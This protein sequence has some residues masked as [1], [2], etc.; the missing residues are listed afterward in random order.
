MQAPPSVEGQVRWL[1]D[2]AQI[3][4]LLVEYARLVDTKD[5]DTLTGYFVD[6][7]K[8]VLPFFT[9]SKEEIAPR[10]LEGLAPYVATHH[11]SANH[12]ITIDGDTASSRSYLQAVHVP[13]GDDLDRHGDVGGW[14]DCTYRR[15]PEGWRFVEVNLTFVWTRGAADLP[16]A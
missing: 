1:V 5:F 11:L 12:A 14:Y 7:G 10:S 9:L 15:T 4:D 8:L 6:G 3:G 13:D 16:G 2:R